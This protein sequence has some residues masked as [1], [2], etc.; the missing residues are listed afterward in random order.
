VKILEF[1][2]FLIAD[3]ALLMMNFSGSGRTVDEFR[4]WLKRIVITWTNING[5]G[6]IMSYITP[7]YWWYM[8]TLM[9]II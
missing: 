7:F 8:D 4:A 2:H 5:I 3:S 6:F 9:L 1:Q